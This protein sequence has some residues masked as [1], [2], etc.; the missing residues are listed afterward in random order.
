M[1]VKIIQGRVV[2]QI[3][4]GRVEQFS[5][6]GLLEIPNLVREHLARFCNCSI[7]EIAS[8]IMEAIGTER[9]EHGI[10]RAK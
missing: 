5:G 10:A 8:K 7:L 2:V 1:Q 4:L 9:D 3:S 6:L